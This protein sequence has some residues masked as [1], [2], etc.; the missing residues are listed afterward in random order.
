MPPTVVQFVTTTSKIKAKE[1]LLA[2]AI[3][4]QINLIFSVTLLLMRNADF[5]F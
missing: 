1:N 4:F 3:S 5:E 2:A